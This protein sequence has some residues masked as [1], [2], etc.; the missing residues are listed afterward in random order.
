MTEIRFC[1]RRNVKVKTTVVSVVIRALSAVTPKLGKWFQQ[2]PGTTSEIPVQKATVLGV[3]G[4]F[5]FLFI[6]LFLFVC[7]GWC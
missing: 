4:G 7:F 5:F 3:R 2:S 1:G 6:Y